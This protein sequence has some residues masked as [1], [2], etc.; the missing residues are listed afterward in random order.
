MNYF[1]EIELKVALPFRR[2]ILDFDGCYTD[3][4]T[5]CLWIFYGRVFILVFTHLVM[6]HGRRLSVSGVNYL[7]M[8]T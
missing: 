1:K 5:C 2:H 3:F 8:T 7:K 4:S 6:H